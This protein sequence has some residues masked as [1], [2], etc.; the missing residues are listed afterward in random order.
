MSIAQSSIR[1]V[2]CS[3]SPSEDA[4]VARTVLTDARLVELHRAD[5]LSGDRGDVA[6][7]HWGRLAHAFR[8]GPRPNLPGWIFGRAHLDKRQRGIL[9]AG[10]VK[11]SNT[12]AAGLRFCQR[13][14]GDEQRDECNG[15]GS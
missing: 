13:G 12:H 2:L 9:S 7:L 10:D 3:N 8:I 1:L 6:K 14:H 15:N 4:W 11:I 5:F